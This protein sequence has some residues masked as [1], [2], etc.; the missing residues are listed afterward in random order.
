MFRCLKANYKAISEILYQQTEI[1]HLRHLTVHKSIYTSRES[2]TN[3][4][5]TG[6]LFYKTYL[7]SFC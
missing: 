7:H 1:A 5:F 6:I 4:T 3:S 2:I